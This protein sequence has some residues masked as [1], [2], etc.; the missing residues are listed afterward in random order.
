MVPR[1]L[2]PFDDKFK[3]EPF[4]SAMWVHA[5]FVKKLFDRLIGVVSS[6][7]RIRLELVLS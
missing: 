3:I 6:D 5:K 7:T 2:L 1:S 4:M